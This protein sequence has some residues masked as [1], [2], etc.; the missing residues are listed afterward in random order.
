MDGI[1]LGESD[2]FYDCVFFV[3]VVRF[4]LGLLG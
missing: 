3:R 2:G 1:F 4:L